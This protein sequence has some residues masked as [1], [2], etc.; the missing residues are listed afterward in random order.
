MDIMKMSLVKIS[1]SDGYEDKNTIF[2]DAA[3][4][5]LVEIYRRFRGAYCLHHQGEEDM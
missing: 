3:P 4:C 1:G 5:R 2:W